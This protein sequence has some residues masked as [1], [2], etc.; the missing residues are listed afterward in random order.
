MHIKYKVTCLWK[1]DTKTQEIPKFEVHA[2]VASTIN[3]TL[4]LNFE[5][6]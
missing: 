4:G 5:R 2:A 1:D 3:K 6:Y